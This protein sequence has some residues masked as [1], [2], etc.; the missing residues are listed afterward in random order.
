MLAGVN[1][2]FSNDIAIDLGTANTV[3]HVANRGIVL[4]EP[5]VVAIYSQKSTANI[6]A[7]GSQAA[8]IIE[9]TPKMIEATYPVRCGVIADSIRTGEMLFQFVKKIKTRF[10]LRKPRILISIPAGATPVEK[11]LV[12]DTALTLGARKVYML[13]KPLAAAFGAGIKIEQLDTAMVVDIGSGTT[14][15]AVI[16]S[17][18]VLL[19]RSLRCAGNAMNKAIVRFIRRKHQLL[20]GEANAEKIKIQAGTA[21]GL[22]VD[23]YT[24][25]H[26]RGINIKTGKQKNIVLKPTDIA[27]ALST[28]V[29]HIVEFIQNSIEDLPSDKI[30]DICNYGIH[31]T[32]GSAKMN[33]LDVELRRRLKGIRITVPEEPTHC[34]VKGA[35]IVLKE[36]EK[37]K[38]LTIKP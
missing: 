38:N 36:L 1:T 27:E 29:Q 23:N 34:V 5:S 30:A 3:I 9:Q 18:S 32:G 19:T 14:D 7:A 15:T 13:E 12:Y 33:S 25:I 11:K 16:S 6:V 26:I 37:F 10:A 22:E 4:D 24:E 2:T 8:K 31:L 20:V 17:G 35:A 21:L 28:P